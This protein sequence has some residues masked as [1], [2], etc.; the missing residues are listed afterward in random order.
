MFV[1]KSMKKSLKNLIKM[2]KRSQ[3]TDIERGQILA[4]RNA[5]V[6]QIDIVQKIGRDPSII[7]RFLASPEEH[8]RRKCPESTVN[9]SLKPSG[10]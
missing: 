2:P 9:F 8:G 6:P 1:S 7:S 3:L 4:Y 10:V 5:N